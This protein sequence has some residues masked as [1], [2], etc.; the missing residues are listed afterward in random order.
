MINGDAALCI[1]DMHAVHDSQVGEAIDQ[2]LAVFTLWILGRA[3]Q[4]SP[5]HKSIRVLCSV[6]RMQTSL[7]FGIAQPARWHRAG[8]SGATPRVDAT[9]LVV[10]AFQNSY[11]SASV[12]FGECDKLG[13]AGS[14]VIKTQ[15]DTDQAVECTI[16][17]RCGQVHIDAPEIPSE[18]QVSRLHKSIREAR[19]GRRGLDEAFEL[20]LHR[21]PNAPT[22]TRGCKAH[23]GRPDRFE[24]LGASGMRPR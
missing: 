3:Q 24:G 17:P 10:D 4:R 15:C 13:D 6:I 11:L 22:T 18:E 21:Y 20:L 19:V 8:T 1:V 23:H 9:E 2:R 7:L 14:S 12:R 16:A 5:G